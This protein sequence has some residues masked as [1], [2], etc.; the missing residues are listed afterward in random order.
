[1]LD[2]EFDRPNE[3]Q[4]QGPGEPPV[5]SER[6][7]FDRAAGATSWAADEAPIGATES[8]P[9]VVTPVAPV[10]PAA[11]RPR[12]T[13]GVQSVLAASLLSAVVAAAGTA[14][15]VTGPLAGSL[16]GGTLAATAPAAVTT[17]SGTG[18][19]TAGASEP[20]LTDVVAAV[21][22]SVVTIT[23]K[24]VS[25]RGLLSIPSTGVGS[26]IVLT[27]NG[28]IL[29]NRHVVEGASQSLT[30]ELADGRQFDATLVKISSDRTSP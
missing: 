7:A 12:R 28:Y 27:S 15:L 11:S 18:S 23:S 25:S 16:G 30:V 24:G 8:T 29:T 10:A 17:A 19:S 21:K 1:M 14:A 20:A 9:P 5:F 4:P 26:G 2:N 6:P 3:Q 13:A 22:D